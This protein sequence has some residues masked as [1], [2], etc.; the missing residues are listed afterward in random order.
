LAI[1]LDL[2]IIWGRIPHWVADVLPK[3]VTAIYN[4]YSQRDN[5]YN[6]I[7]LAAKILRK[8]KN[9]KIRQEKNST[10]KEAKSE[11]STNE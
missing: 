2:A 9:N 10:R 11:A 3:G 1:V 4:K 6:E 7:P 8:K 5:K